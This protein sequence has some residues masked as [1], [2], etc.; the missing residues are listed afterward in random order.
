MLAPYTNTE[1]EYQ[2]AALLVVM[3]YAFGRASDLTYIP[4]FNLSLSSDNVI[5]IRLIRAKISEEQG[6]SFFPDKDSFI[7]CPINAVAMALAM[8][9]FPSACLLNL[10][11]SSA[12]DDTDLAINI[13]QTPFVDVL[14]HCVDDSDHENLEPPAPTRRR[15]AT[16]LKIQGYVNRVL[17]GAVANLEKADITA[18]LSSHSFR[19]GEHANG[20]PT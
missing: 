19:R 12:S 16:P 20:D 11:L 14:L 8:Q 3:W 4:K 15:H 10:A 6:L 17:K 9:I 13:D 2:D 5:F 7:T 1:T 18:N